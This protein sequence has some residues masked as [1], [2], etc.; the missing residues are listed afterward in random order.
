MRRS[1]SFQGELLDARGGGH[2]I[3]VDA[4]LVA[5]LGAKHMTRVAGTVNSTPFRSSMVRYSGQMYLGV[6]KETIQAAGAAVGETVRV[7]MSLDTEPRDG[8][9]KR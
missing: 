8:D 9:A 4:A 5:S 7:D 3:A 6:H 2:A 1:I